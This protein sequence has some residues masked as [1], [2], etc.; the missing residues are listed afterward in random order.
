MLKD[1]RLVTVLYLVFVWFLPMSCTEYE[2][3]LF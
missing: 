2:S 1:K 3:L